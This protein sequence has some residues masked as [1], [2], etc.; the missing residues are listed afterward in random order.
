MLVTPAAVQPART[1]DT[2]LRL[3]LHIVSLNS[4]IQCCV[5]DF[6]GIDSNFSA[7]VRFSAPVPFGGYRCLFFAGKEVRALQFEN[8]NE[9][10]VYELTRL[11]RPGTPEKAVAVLL[12]KHPRKRHDANRSAITKPTR[13]DEGDLHTAHDYFKKTKNSTRP[14]ITDDGK[15]VEIEYKENVFEHRK[16]LL[17][18]MRTN[19]EHRFQT[20]AALMADNVPR[21]KYECGKYKQCMYSYD[22]VRAVVALVVDMDDHDYTDPAAMRTH[23]LEGIA[24]LQLM[25]DN[26]QCGA[27]P[28]PAIEDSGRGIHLWWIF[29]QAIPYAADTDTATWYKNLATAIKSR[30]TDITKGLPYD[31]KVD[32]CA[33]AAYRV[34]NLPGSM[35]DST[36]T[37]RWVVN[38]NWQSV[39]VAALCAALGVSSPDGKQK[40]APAAEKP[41]KKPEVKVVDKQ[42]ETDG[43]AALQPI[44]TVQEKPK[45]PAGRKVYLQTEQSKLYNAQQRVQ[46][47]VDWAALR[48]FR[49]V[50][51][52]NEWLA[53]IANM[54]YSGGGVLVT[55]DMLQEY[56]N[57]LAVPLDAAELA[58]IIKTMCVKKYRPRKN[59]TI[60][61]NLHMTEDE[62]EAID[63]HA[64]R[65]KTRDKERAKRKTARAME[66]AAAAAAKAAKAENK[67]KTKEKARQLLASG[68]S[69]RE[70]AQ[71]TGLGKSS[72]QRLKG[73][74]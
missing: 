42:P 43:T 6:K 51:Y 45:K 39:D 29:S 22:D 58:S 1:G 38:D 67:E 44:P 72:V 3:P 33:T 15:E 20:Y 52:R 12:E 69:V 26:G 11:D 71:Q 46:Q 68:M 50:G 28:V 65:N 64:N 56:N 57:M 2:V 54:L 4:I 60:A 40:P 53:N 10:L 37:L 48:D 21:G 5:V 30:I 61:K 17:E 19:P 41:P 8:Q 23:L 14:I 16:P 25:W 66:K 24:A 9:R 7:A 74:E 47:L 73:N 13:W 55:V 27:L 36:G 18:E 35:N 32:E 49:L 63:F 34:Y 70:V 31:F 62:Q 59:S